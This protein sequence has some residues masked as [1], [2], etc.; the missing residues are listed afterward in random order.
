MYEKQFFIQMSFRQEFLYF[1]RQKSEQ[2]ISI[3]V[4][5]AAKLDLLDQLVG[6]VIHLLFG[7][8]DVEHVEDKG[9]QDG[10]DQDIYKNADRKTQEIRRGI[11]KTCVFWQKVWSTVSFCLRMIFDDT[12]FNIGNLP[13]KLQNTA[14]LGKFSVNVVPEKKYGLF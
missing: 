11:P 2:G 10:N 8:D 9:K 7:G 14:N 5:P 1:P 13:C 6:H 12:H 3:A 4:R